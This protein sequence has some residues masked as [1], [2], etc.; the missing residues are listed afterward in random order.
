MNSTTDLA[1]VIA[2]ISMV[3]SF[4]HVNRQ[5][6]ET[7]IRHAETWMHCFR[8]ILEHTGTA[9]HLSALSYVDGDDPCHHL[10]GSC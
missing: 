6:D 4:L 1:H 8:T 3:Q 9:P 7:R 10:D 2:M 5:I